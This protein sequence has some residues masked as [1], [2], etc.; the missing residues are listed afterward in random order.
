MIPRIKTHLPILA[1]V[2]ISAL[3]TFGI[4]WAHDVVRIVEPALQAAVLPTRPV[5]NDPM[6][7][8][9]LAS[10]DSTSPANIESDLRTLELNVVGEELADIQVLLGNQ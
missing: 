4:L 3:G 9:I 7:E 6:I 10:G 2:L 8:K 1:I 5:I